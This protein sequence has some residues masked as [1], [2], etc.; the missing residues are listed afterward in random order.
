MKENLC[1]W[2]LKVFIFVIIINFKIV[3]SSVI[4]SSS[5]ICFI[6]VIKVV[7]FNFIIFRFIVINSHFPG[8]TSSSIFHRLVV[9][10][11]G[12]GRVIGNIFWCCITVLLKLIVELLWL[13]CIK[14]F[15]NIATTVPC[16]TNNYCPGT[17]AC[18]LCGF[19]QLCGYF[20]YSAV[21]IGFIF[22]SAT[23]CPISSG[24]IFHASASSR[25]MSYC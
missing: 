19:L 11:I 2:L 5:A 10:W 8:I 20:Y 18:E 9:T 16:R 6:V 14:L 17:V 23:I 22:R 15:K 25:C 21:C 24:C 1:M 13:V 7:I 4:A 12:D 3:S